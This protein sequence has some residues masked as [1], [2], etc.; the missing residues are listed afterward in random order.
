MQQIEMGD[1]AFLGIEETIQKIEIV[2]ENKTKHQNQERKQT[3]Q[4]IN[5]LTPDFIH[6]RNLW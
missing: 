5:A 4:K 6:F 2:I 1:F 3:K